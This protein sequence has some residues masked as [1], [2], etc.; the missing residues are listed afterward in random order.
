MPSRRIFCGLWYVFVQ[1][2]SRQ[3]SPNEI[4]LRTDRA[5]FSQM[6]VRA[7]TRKLSTSPVFSHPFGPLPWAL[8]SA[9]ANVSLRKTNKLDS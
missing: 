7:E 5:L 1:T 2:R 3:G 9:I 6:I 8:S 4:F